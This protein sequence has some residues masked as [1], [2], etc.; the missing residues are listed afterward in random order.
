MVNDKGKEIIAVESLG[1]QRKG[2]VWDLSGLL[3]YDIST[4]DVAT[5]G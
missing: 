3:S 5:D 4:S 2:R 1:G